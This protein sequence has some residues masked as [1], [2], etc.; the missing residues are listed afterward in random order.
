[1]P[2]KTIDKLQKA[3]ILEARKMMAEAERL[4]CN[5]AETRRRMFGAFGMS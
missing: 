1:M 3:A 2:K 5:E 4:D